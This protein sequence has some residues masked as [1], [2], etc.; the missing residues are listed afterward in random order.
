[1]ATRAITYHWESQ[2][3]HAYMILEYHRFTGADI[4]HY[5]PFIKQSLIFFDKHYRAQQKIRNGKELDDN[6][7]LVIISSTSCESYRGAM[8]PSYLI[9]D[10]YKSESELSIINR[11]GKYSQGGKHENRHESVWKRNVPLA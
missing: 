9:S 2:V 11:N 6:D 5:M 8:N 3:E 4:S 7:K 1:M 10:L